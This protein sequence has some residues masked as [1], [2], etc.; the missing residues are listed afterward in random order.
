MK[1]FVVVI[2]AFVL[3][4]ILA[5]STVSFASATLDAGTYNDHQNA[6]STVTINI[7]G[8][9]VIVI[10]GFHYDSGDLG[11]GDVIRIWRYITE[12]SRYVPVAIFT[13]IPE[14][15]DLFNIIY[16]DYS[17][18]VQLINDP[19][20]IKVV[21][22]GNSKNVHV[23]WK[24][25]LIVPDEQWGPPANKIWVLGIT[26]PPG[27][28]VTR[29]HGESFSGSSSSSSALYSQTVT[30]DMGYYGDATFV[31]P[32]WHFGGPVGVNQGPY[33]TSIRLNTMVET[34]IN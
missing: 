28:L 26:I 1:K 11:A 27:M 31:C 7:E 9:P 19:S 23:V 30:G 2:L 8:H 20:I 10:D 22:E 12:F 21:R 24:T 13:D 34:I 16:S 33:R 4:M 32:T 3:M 14:R 17:T 29:G 6:S 15:V 25:D 18:S 5:V